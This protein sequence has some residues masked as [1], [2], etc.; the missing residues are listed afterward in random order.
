MDELTPLELAKAKRERA[1]NAVMALRMALLREETVRR[2][3]YALDVA[4]FDV[5]F[6]GDNDKRRE[7]LDAIIAE[8]PDVI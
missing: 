1:V 4:G 5:A 2:V 7:A 8:E 3:I 6:R